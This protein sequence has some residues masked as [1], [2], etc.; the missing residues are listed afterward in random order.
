MQALVVVG[1]DV[2]LQDLPQCCS[3]LLWIPVEGISNSGAITTQ[4]DVHEHQRS[5]SFRQS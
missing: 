1:W 2:V 4:S 3:A 5:A